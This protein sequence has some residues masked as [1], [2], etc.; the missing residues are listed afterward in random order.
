MLLLL[1]IFIHCLVS[2]SINVLLLFK[3]ENFQ[4]RQNIA[5]SMLHVM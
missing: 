2:I 3:A 1:Y 5:I 4:V